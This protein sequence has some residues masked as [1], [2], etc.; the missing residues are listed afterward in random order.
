M[1]RFSIVISFNI[2]LESCLTAH[3]SNLQHLSFHLGC[4]ILTVLLE[5]SSPNIAKKFHVGHLRSTII[6][7]FLINLYRTCGWDTVA[8]NYLGDWGKQFGLI[9]VG[10]EKY[11]NDEAMRQDPI[12]HLYDVYVKINADADADPAVH[13]A[14]RAHFKRMEDGEESA[15]LQWRQ[16]RADSIERY[17]EEYKVLNVEFD[18]YIGESMVGREV[19]LG[20]IQKLTDM[21]LVEVSENA[22]RIDLETN[23]KL[24][25]PVL[26][27][28]GEFPPPLCLTDTN[29]L[30]DG[31][32]I[33][34]TRDIGGAIERWQGYKFD[35]MIYVVANQ[36]DM[37]VAQFFKI[38]DL[39][40][41]EWAN[42]LEHINFGMVTGMSTR[43]GT[44]V[45]LDQ[46]IKDSQEV[47]LEQMQKNEEKYRQIENPEYVAREIGITAIKVQDMQAKR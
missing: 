18:E 38:L 46:I 39:M 4:N 33:Y 28:T 32:T 30:P 43:K 42:R 41:Y 15:L 16:W 10:Y 9:A 24:G 3:N 7:A 40:G 25:K 17:K 12:K 45:F 27:K 20:A 31:T 37:H 21:G 2:L 13:D 1:F 5:Y 44:A 26:L 36:Q 8:L 14:A 35:K 22:T 19:Q 47:M 29:S 6:G 23:Y 34:L 11:G